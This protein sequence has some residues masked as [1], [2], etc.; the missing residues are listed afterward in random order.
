MARIG[1]SIQAGLNQYDPTPWLNASARASAS[2]GD[3]VSGLL[4]KFT[5]D[6][7]EKK[8]FK[9]DIRSGKEIG[10]AL[11]TLDPGLEA[12]LAPFL[13]RLDDGEIPESARAQ[14]AQ[15][16]SALVEAWLNKQTEDRGYGLQA[17]GVDLNERGVALRESAEG[18]ESRV[19]ESNFEDGQRWKEAEMETRAQIAPRLIENTIGVAKEIEA[20][21]GIPPISSAGLQN[22]LQTGTPEQKIQVSESFMGMLPQRAKPEF[23]EIPVTIDGQPATATAIFDYDVG[24]FEIVPVGGGSA[25]G[26]SPV[27]A[28]DLPKG[29][30]KFSNAFNEAGARHGVDPKALAAIA[31]HETGNGTSPAFLKKNNAMG[32]SN[33]KGP[34]AMESVEQSIDKMA[35]LLGNAQGGPYRDTDQISEIAGKYAPV[36]AGNDPRGLNKFWTDGVASNY[37][38]LG[39]DPSA[40][41]RI[42]PGAA[43]GK[44]TP[45]KTEAEL[46]KEQLEIQK[47]Q[48]ELANQGATRDQDAKKLEDAKAKANRLLET[49]KKYTYVDESS[50][51]LK[52][53]KRLDDAVGFGGGIGKQINRA[54]D[55]RTLADQQ[56]LERFVEQDLLEA[57]KDL[58]PVSEDEMKLL[59][60]RRPKVGDKPEAWAAYMEDIKEFIQE[61]TGEALPT[62]K[63]AAYY[64]EALESLDDAK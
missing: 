46:Q 30:S 19:F 42:T 35:S 24:R 11:S 8:K 17:R 31:M 45:P 1:D 23:R 22:I 28:S 59:M 48:G 43:K 6:I 37:R 61:K 16:T 27:S 32:I 55:G 62:T 51:A 41:V 10:K 40:P 49:I 9:D 14:M 63:E 44:P 50:G 7:D 34:V 52:F 5:A 12:N 39:G 33:S 13:E 56:A 38:A 64:N 58:K 4:D 29:L 26:F 18:R 57:T 36:G 20:S 15:A 47:L 3:S 21:G 60:S 25:G 53:N 54:I 2:I